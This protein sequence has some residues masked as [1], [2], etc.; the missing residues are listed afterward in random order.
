MSAPS[1]PSATPGNAGPQPTAGAQPPLE[2]QP[3]PTGAASVSQAPV[4][5]TLEPSPTPRGPVKHHRPWG[6][7]VVCTVLVL[8]A[9]G[10]AVWAL[11]LNSDLSDQQDQTAQ[12]QQ[13]AQKATDEV[14]SLSA[15][16]D[17][18]SQSVDQA[19]QDLSQAGQDAQDNAQQTLDGLKGKL[20]TAKEKIGQAIGDANTDP[21]AT[22]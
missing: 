21:A 13:Q 19:S 1:D 18:I 22:P 6:W 5:A 11:G 2:A 17:D 16:V 3:L 8:V 15:E 10:L 4:Y 9:G 20:A 12:A 14:N 7:I